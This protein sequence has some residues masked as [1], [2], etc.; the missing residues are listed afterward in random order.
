VTGNIMGGKDCAG[1]G[2]AAHLGSD[3]CIAAGTIYQLSKKGFF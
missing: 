3:Q 2:R 1:D